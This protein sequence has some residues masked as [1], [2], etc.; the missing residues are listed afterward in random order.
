MR[1]TKDLCRVYGHIVSLSGFDSMDE[2]NQTQ[3]HNN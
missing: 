3:L 1:N 2:L